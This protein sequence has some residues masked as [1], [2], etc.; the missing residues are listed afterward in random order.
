MPTT[1]RAKIVGW[2]G[3][4]YTYGD[5]C[6]VTVQAESREEAC[7]IM[8]RLG[9][10]VQSE[11]QVKPTVTISGC[12]VPPEVDAMRP[13]LLANAEACQCEEEPCNATT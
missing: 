6:L 12:N 7:D 3:N 1:K 10:L 8:R 11:R 13:L 2:S 5:A 4:F 9:L